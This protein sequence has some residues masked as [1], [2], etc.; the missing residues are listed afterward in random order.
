MQTYVVVRES[1]PQGVA[2]GRILAEETMQI[3][4]AEGGEVMEVFDKLR[5]KRCKRKIYDRLIEICSIEANL[6]APYEIGLP[7]A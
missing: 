5:E 1:E 6:G 4:R 3:I 2:R 7:P